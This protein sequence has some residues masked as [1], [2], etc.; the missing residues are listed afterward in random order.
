MSVQAN[1]MGAASVELKG[2]R[3]FYWSVRRELWEHRAVYI[4]PVAAAGVFVS[5]FVISLRGMPHLMRELPGMSPEQQHGS[6]VVPYDMASGLLMLTQMLI[7]AFYCLDAFSS[8]RRDRSILFWKSLPVSD[9]T[10]V[11]A[12]AAVALAVLPMIIVATILFLHL[13]IL[14]LSTLVVAANGQSVSQLWELVSLPRMILM[15][16][17]H[18]LTV[19]TLWYAPL[20]GWLLFVSA[21]ARRAAYLWAFLPPL[22]I[23]FLERVVL[24]TTHFGEFMMNRL[25]GGTDAIAPPGRMPIDTMTH[26]TPLSFL[27][28]PGLW[29]GFAATAGFIAL[30]V[31]ARRYRE[32]N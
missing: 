19:H 5:G 32:P 4:G 21:W 12:K 8:E 22:A 11:L 17:Y 28:D 2:M 9:R 10:A 20:Y 23:G 14:L 1:A 24:G 26:L 16:S 31:R 29:V 3:T 13:A 15:V 7:G 18:I 30:A 6:I 27:S 25:G